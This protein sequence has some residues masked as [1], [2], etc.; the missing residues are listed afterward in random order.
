MPG[1]VNQAGSNAGS[2]VQVTLIAAFQAPANQQI[3]IN[4][5]KCSS[6]DP[7]AGVDVGSSVFIIQQADDSAFSVNVV[8]KDRTVV[9]VSDT[10]MTTYGAES[11]NGRLI[12]PPGKYCRVIGYQIG[13]T[14]RF[15]TGLVGQTRWLDSSHGGRQVD[16]LG[17]D[18]L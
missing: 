17:D 5:W 6:E 1:N 13:T 8:E 7:A 9:P 12:I 18:I 4:D 3:E 10:Y 14:G 2:A 16:A 11:G 15:T